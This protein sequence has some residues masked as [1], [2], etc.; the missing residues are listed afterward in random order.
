MKK[1]I[2]I[3]AVTML[4]LGMVSVTA[5][6]H[7]GHGLGSGTGHR[8]EQCTVEGCEAVGPHRHGDTWYCSRTWEEGNYE[9][10]PVEGCSQLGL[11]EH[12]GTYY[13]CASHGTGRGCGRGWN[14]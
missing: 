8:Y 6:A 9:L 5:F 14:R 1:A 4:V 2:S 13:Y 12:D 10:C 3:L 11:H 7:G